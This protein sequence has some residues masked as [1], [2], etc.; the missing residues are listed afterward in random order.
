VH[1]EVS[2]RLIKQSYDLARLPTMLK[3]PRD[4]CLETNDHVGSATH[5]NKAVIGYIAGSVYVQVFK[6]H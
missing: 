6:V 5:E 1:D 4:L 3:N 2:N